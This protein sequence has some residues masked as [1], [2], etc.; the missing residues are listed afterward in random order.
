MHAVGGG[1]VGVDVGV[2]GGWGGGVGPA[3]A[4]VGLGELGAGDEELE[5]LGGLFGVGRGGGGLTR[6]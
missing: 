5:M 3:V 2:V 1:S 6:W 4:R